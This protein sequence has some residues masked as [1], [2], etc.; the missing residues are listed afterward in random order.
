MFSLHDTRQ[1]TAQTSLA[2]APTPTLPTPH[3]EAHPDDSLYSFLQP[4]LT[5]MTTTIIVV[6]AIITTAVS[7]FPQS[8]AFLSP[9]VTSFCQHRQLLAINADSRPQNNNIFLLSLEGT[10]LSSTHSKSCMAI[11][12]AFTVW[13]SLVETAQTL[14]LNPQSLEE[15]SWN[16][17]I[18]KLNALSSIT[19][20]GLGCDAVFL[21]RVLLE[22]Q[23][24]DGGRSNG[25]GGKYGGKYHPTWTSDFDSDGSV[26]GS[27]PLTVGELFANWEE[28]R[29]VM[30]FKYPVVDEETGRM[31][32]PMP[33]IRDALNELMLNRGLGIQDTWHPFACDVLM[34]NM[35]VGTENNDTRQNTIVVLGHETQLKWTLDSLAS[36][37]MI[38]AVDVDL[39]WE[40]PYLNKWLESEDHENPGLRISV[41]SST[42]VRNH[43]SNQQHNDSMMIVVP[44]AEKEETQSEI[45]KRIVIDFQKQTQIS[46]A[47]TETDDKF[48]ITVIHTSLDV[49]KRCKSIV[50]DSNRISLNLLMPTWADNIHPLELDESEADSQLC[51]VTESQFLNSILCKT[52]A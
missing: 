24:L 8:A 11:Q 9:R 7:T 1:E 20:Q 36:M 14:N 30:E 48:D 4:G 16:W 25:R 35:N 32:N 44:N 33:K 18:E 10:L 45:I 43:Y 15:E 27:R 3:H 52:W 28:L 23:L 29:E 42:K 49:L 47:F 41:T 31:M 37:G 19:Q 39:D 46:S 17:L 2:T 51:I 21:A 22:E 26:V 12:A 38:F 6:L 40:A 34:A 5:T 13:P 50:R